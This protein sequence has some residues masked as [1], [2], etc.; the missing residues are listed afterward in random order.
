MTCP[1]S[2]GTH[3]TPARNCTEE[4]HHHSLFFCPLHIDNQNLPP[5]WAPLH[6]HNSLMIALGPNFESHE[7]P[8]LTCFTFWSSNFLSFSLFFSREEVGIS[9][10][11]IFLA[12]WSAIIRIRFVFLISFYYFI[13][14][15]LKKNNFIKKYLNIKIIDGSSFMI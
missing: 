14:I 10:V 3:R 7:A 9:W 13:L 1:L 2:D 12:H 4:H 6:V 5:C 11:F 15:Y 8:E